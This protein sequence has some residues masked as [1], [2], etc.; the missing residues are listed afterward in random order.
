MFPCPTFQHTFCCHSLTSGEIDCQP[1]G[2][3]RC[4]QLVILSFIEKPGG[5]IKPGRTIF[6]TVIK[7]KQH[8][9]HSGI[10]LQDSKGR[11]LKTQI[12]KYVLQWPDLKRPIFAC[13]RAI[14]PLSPWSKLAFG[15]LVMAMGIYHTI[16]FDCEVLSVGIK[17]GGCVAGGHSRIRRQ[18][19]VGYCL[20][21]SVVSTSQQFRW[22][23]SR[24]TKKHF[25]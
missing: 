24:G 23:C 15:R 25:L 2:K 19:S 16:S 20:L 10:P 4:G 7:R 5:Q 9:R 14:W 6:S 17:V 12:E 18:D 1:P 13:T 22:R 11:H 21:S 3:T 8:H